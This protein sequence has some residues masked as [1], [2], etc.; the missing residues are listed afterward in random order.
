M[1]QVVQLLQ[2]AA[3]AA[4]EIPAANAAGAIPDANQAFLLQED[5]LAQFR[6]LLVNYQ[7]QQGLAGA[8]AARRADLRPPGD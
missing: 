5:I 8:R 6:K 7:R 3:S 2:H 1:Q 4:G